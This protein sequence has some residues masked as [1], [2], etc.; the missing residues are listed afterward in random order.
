[1]PHVLRRSSRR[2]TFREGAFAPHTNEY[3]E[4]SERRPRVTSRGAVDTTHL[5]AFEIGH[6][7]HAQRTSRREYRRGD[8]VRHEMRRTSRN[9]ENTGLCAL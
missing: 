4:Q 1:M 8:H 6:V 3:M 5:T 2:N 7:R 9:D